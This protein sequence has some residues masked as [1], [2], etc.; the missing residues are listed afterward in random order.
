MLLETKEK[1]ISQPL[2]GD[3]DCGPR[4]SEHAVGQ[5]GAS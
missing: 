1:G 5:D 3:G 4:I 2:K